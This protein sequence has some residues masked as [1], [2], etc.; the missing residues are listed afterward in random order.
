MF[1]CERIPTSNCKVKF[2]IDIEQT[3]HV[4]ITIHMSL[5]SSALPSNSSGLLDAHVHAESDLDTSIQRT[6]N[7]TTKIVLSFNVSYE[8]TRLKESHDS[9]NDVH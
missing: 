1:A 7:Q 3:A 6:E 9:Q 8:R 4:S 5:F 2:F